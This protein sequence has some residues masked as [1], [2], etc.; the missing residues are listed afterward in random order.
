MITP[1]R[2]KRIELTEEFLGSLGF[3]QIRAR[4]HGDLVRIEIGH[5]EMDRFL[6]ADLRRQVA[7]KVK[8]LGYTYVCLDLLGYRT[9]AMNEAPAV[10]MNGAS[11]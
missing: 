5:A 7:E 6:A 9:G 10:V 2:L 11:E 3:V 1:E 8:A 4:D